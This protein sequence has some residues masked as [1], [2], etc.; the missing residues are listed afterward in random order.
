M[1]LA[2]VLSP[3]GKRGGVGMGYSHIWAIWGCTA[4]QLNRVQYVFFPLCQSGTGSTNR[5]FRLEQGIPFTHSDSRTRSGSGLPLS[6]QNYS[7]NRVQSA[8]SSPEFEF[9]YKLECQRSSSSPEFKCVTDIITCQHS[10]LLIEQLLFIT[11]CDRVVLQSATALFITKCDKVVLQS[12]TGIIQSAT[13]VITKCDRYYKVRRYYKVWQ[14]T[15]QDW[16]WSVVLEFIFLIWFVDWG[17]DWGFHL[18]W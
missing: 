9:D 15:W 18:T 4:Q 11:K 8:S 1:V 14:Y 12:A 5:R 16:N 3:R 2:A 17:Y 7:S 10:G 13:S 6:C